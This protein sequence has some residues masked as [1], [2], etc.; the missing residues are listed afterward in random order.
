M[1]W[2]HYS[3]MR[4]GLIGAWV[5]AT[6]LCPAA[7][8]K[9]E[10]PVDRFNASLDRRADI[11]ADATTLIRNRWA[12]CDQCDAEEFLTQAL[13][14]VSPRFREAL[15]AYD[16]DDYAE[17]AEIMHGLSGEADPFIAINAA[18]YEIKSLVAMDRTLEAGDRIREL[19]AREAD[20]AA[21]SYAAPELAFLRG[22]CLLTDLQYEAAESA[23]KKFLADHG[24]ASARLAI[25]ARQILVELANR[26]S[27]RLGDVVDLMDFSRRRLKNDDPGDVVR[28]R[29]QQIIDLLDKL[30][31]DAEE[32]EKQSGS[33]G[34]SGGS[35]PPSGGAPS[36]PMQQ[37]RL[38]GGD[39][40]GTPARATR[41]ANPGDAWGSMPPAERERVLQALRDAFPG[42]YRQLVE[43]YYEELAKKP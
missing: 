21:H 38:P 8:A 37:S 7:R 26:E 31:K 12:E 22:Y 30:I 15:D 40:G 1:A 10:S 11:P 18:A 9:A 17:C 29:Q 35:G 4:K 5:L 32:K 23:L 41:R 28:T 3:P 16:A 25:S 33:A 2:G 14:V 6:A 42:R 24:N 36:N 27:G 39:P 19:G 43:Q 20:V 13:A 34:S